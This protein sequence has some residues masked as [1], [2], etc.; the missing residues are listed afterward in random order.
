MPT[1]RH[2]LNNGPTSA[3]CGKIAMASAS[4]SNSFL[5]G[6]SNLAIAYAANIATITDNSVASSEMPIELIN[7][8]VNS[9]WLN[10]SAK[11]SNDHDVGRNCGSPETM[12]DGGLIAR[13][14]IHSRGKKL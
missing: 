8:R 10:T 12:S 1:L 2:M 4:E 14:I 7:A 6:K 9:G 5:P 3:A 11:L 13:L